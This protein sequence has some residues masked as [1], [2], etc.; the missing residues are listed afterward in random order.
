MDEK[1]PGRCLSD[2]HPRR[3][4]CDGRSEPAFGAARYLE[5]LLRE[6][7]PAQKFEVST[8]PITALITHVILPIACECAR[9]TNLT[10]G[11][12]TW[13]N[14]EMSVPS[15]Q[16]PIFRRGRPLCCGLTR[17]LAQRSKGTRLGHADG[18]EPPFW[19]KGRTQTPSWAGMQIVPAKPCTSE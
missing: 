4:S 5:V 11:S 10:C 7:F 1:K 16:P 17:A 6:R 13:G 3:I 12:F 18:L 8:S 9:R 14:N 15:E 19:Q 2:F